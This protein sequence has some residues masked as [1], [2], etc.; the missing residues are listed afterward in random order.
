MKLKQNLLDDRRENP[1]PR[2]GVYGLFCKMGLPL[3]WVLSNLGFEASPKPI[4]LYNCFL[5]S[6]FGFLF[7]LGV[8]SIN[9]SGSQVESF[10]LITVVDKL[11]KSI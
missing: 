8:G 11:G 2:F 1:F 10:F 9:L 6:I 3:N 5:L 7:F 4:L